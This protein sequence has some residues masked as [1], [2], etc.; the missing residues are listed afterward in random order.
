MLA[1]KVAIFALANL[2]CG[3]S[4]WSEDWPEIETREIAFD[5]A[6]D[7]NEDFPLAFDLVFV[8]DPLAVRRLGDLSA[9][10]WFDRKAQLLRDDPQATL[11]RSYEIVP[12][13]HLAPIRLNG[14]EQ[15][16]VAAFLFADYRRAG[17]HRARLDLYQRPVLVLG[18]DT[19]DLRARS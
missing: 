16:A 10:E 15:D 5:V 18:A 19:I 2:L 3:C 17:A 7:L 13:Q 9:S 12:G 6:L 14:E 1:R 4:L 8:R 11:V